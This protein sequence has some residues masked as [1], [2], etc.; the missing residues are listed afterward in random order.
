MTDLT[1]LRT[2]LSE[3][4][5]ARHAIATSGA[6]IEV[7]RGDRRMRFSRENL[8]ALTSYI[9]E[10]QRDIAAAERQASG[11]PRRSAI[12]VRWG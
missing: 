2:W 4:E 10:L 6:V 12:G 5:A 11:R 8:T 9:A 3:A 7:Q 1:T